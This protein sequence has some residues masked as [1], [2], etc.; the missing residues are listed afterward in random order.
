[1]ARLEELQIE[2]I[3]VNPANI[4]SEIDTGTD[5]MQRLT[6][7]LKTMGMVEPLQVYPHPDIEGD[8][9]L[10]DGHRR[11]LAAIAAGLSTVPCL[12]VDAPKRGTLDD[13]EVMMTTGRNHE[14]LTVLEEARGFQALLDLGMNESTIGKKFKKPKSEVVAKAKLTQAPEG[15]QKAYGYQ[16]LD[17]E[18]VKRL[19]ELE[20]GGAADVYERV[21]ARI[22]ER[23]T[24]ATLI[25]MERLILTEERDL[26]KQRLLESVEALGAEKAPYE[27]SYG[28]Q[29]VEAPAMSDHEHAE[30]GD[31]YLI[32]TPYSYDNDNP[33]ST[34]T[35]YRK[36]KKAAVEVSDEEK[37]EKEQLRALA[38]GLGISFQVRRTFLAK[39]VADPLGGVN[40][41]TDQE[42]LFEL[43]WPD[44]SRLDDELLGDITGIHKPE[45]ADEYGKHDIRLGWLGKVEA[46]FRTFS[47]RQLVRAYALYENQDTDKQLRN[48]KN[49]DRTTYEWRTRQKWLTR[50]QTWFG[51]RLDQ[52]EQDVL[53]HFKAKGGTYGHTYR[54][55][56]DQKAELKKHGRV[57]AEDVEVL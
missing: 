17:L 35:W 16:R 14:P 4:R 5:K 36:S 41:A 19:Q 29:W 46:R 40:Q 55:T 7:E 52:S 25:D 45:D 42:M 31:K 1:M 50:L 33:E 53:D 12:I 28:G 23:A 10:R 38:G 49:F 44:I 15:V 21:T 51:Y 20:A 24:G 13:V 9:M 11:R 3:R 34:V 43:L 18:G 30:A 48:V 47:W 22:E 56:D 54:G 32:H 57:L 37:A 27:A 26:E 8:Y 6:A 2:M 39:Q